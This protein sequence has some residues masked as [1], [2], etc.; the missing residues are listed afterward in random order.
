[1][2]IFQV[3][4]WRLEEVNRLGPRSSGS[5]CGARIRIRICR[6]ASLCSL[7]YTL[8]PFWSLHFQSLHS[9][10]R[11][12]KYLE[13]FCCGFHLKMDGPCFQNTL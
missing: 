11:T 5:N 4:K 12:G 13:H 9:V 7:S 10:H 2:S 8:F 6:S 1:M 3:Q